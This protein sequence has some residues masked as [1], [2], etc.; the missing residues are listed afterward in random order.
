MLATIVVNLLRD[1]HCPESKSNKTAYDL[2]MEDKEQKKEI[3]VTQNII[4]GSLTPNELNEK[5][6]NK[7]DNMADSVKLEYRKMAEN[8]FTKKFTNTRLKKYLCNYFTI[9]PTY[10]I[11]KE[12]NLLYNH[13]L[14]RDVSEPHMK[15]K[16]EEDKNINIIIPY[17]SL[18][19]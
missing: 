3:Y 4:E 18:S 16:T 7:W 17:F 11:N 19:F 1:L 10:D 14:S 2:F 8:K 9:N 13:F 12:Y 5:M 6:R 15:N